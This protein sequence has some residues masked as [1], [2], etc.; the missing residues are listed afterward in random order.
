VGAR[1]Q[2]VAFGDFNADGRLDLAVANAES[3]TI[4][5]LMGLGAGLLGAA[6]NYA[7]GSRPMT[8]AAGDLNGDARLDLAVANQF[9]NTVSVLLGQDGGLF[10][11]A[12]SYGVDSQPLGVAVGDLKGDGR[13]DIAVTNADAASLCVLLNHGPQAGTWKNLG[14][15]LAGIAGVPS[16]EGIGS[17]VAGGSCALELAN[18]CPAAACALFASLSSMP[19]AFKGGTLV[20]VPPLLSLAMTTLADGTLP[21]A[22]TWPAGVPAGTS[23]WFQYAISDVAAVQR[24]A[25]SNAVKATTP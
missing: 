6:T 13:L 10:G 2:S 17:L 7:A 4:S 21:L 8:V 1:P 22:F 12:T 24:V 9:S 11:A 14:F 5:V 19:A 20:P 16:L 25:L 15:G 18:A 3:D 23:F